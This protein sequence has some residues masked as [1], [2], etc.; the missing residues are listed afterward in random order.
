[1]GKRKSHTRKDTVAGEEAIRE[2]GKGEES[3]RGSNGEA[4]DTRLWGPEALDRMGTKQ[5][6]L[7]VTTEESGHQICRSHFLSHGR[8]QT[9]LTKSSCYLKLSDTN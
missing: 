6:G 9:N 7:P 2:R 3:K 8:W 4:L 1:M 5:E